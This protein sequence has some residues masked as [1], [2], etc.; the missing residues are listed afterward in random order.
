MS[1]GGSVNDLLSEKVRNTKDVNEV[2]A[3]LSILNEYL[4]LKIRRRHNIRKGS[5]IAVAA[6]A[7]LCLLIIMLI[8]R[9]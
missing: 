7:V 6:A 4:T 3:Q 2:A 9:I 5:L 8:T 1:W